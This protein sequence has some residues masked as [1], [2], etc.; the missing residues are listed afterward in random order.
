MEIKQS[1][2]PNGSIYRTFRATFEMPI[3]RFNHDLIKIG[4]RQ[5]RNAIY[6]AKE[7]HKALG[8]GEYALPAALTRNLKVSRAR[9]TQILNLLQLSPEVLE[10][11]SALGDPLRSPIA[12]ERRLRP[13]LSLTV[14]QQKTQVKS[15][16]QKLTAVIAV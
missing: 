14:D 13:L 12:A 11:I 16:S 8:S 4:K 3:V 9:V 15:C 10:M 7:W 1:G 2:S 6:L 5:Y